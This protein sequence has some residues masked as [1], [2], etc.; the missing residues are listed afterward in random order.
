VFLAALV[1]GSPA[2]AILA[3]QPVAMAT[4]FAQEPGGPQLSDEEQAAVDA[5]KA[6]KDI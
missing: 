5:K 3:D 4:P 2:L 1:L 6:G